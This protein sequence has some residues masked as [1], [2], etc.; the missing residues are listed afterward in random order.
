MR[1]ASIVAFCY[2]PGIHAASNSKAWSLSLGIREDVSGPS[3]STWSQQL[4]EFQDSRT[5][6][7]ASPWFLFFFLF[8]WVPSVDSARWKIPQK[9]LPTPDTEETLLNLSVS[10]RAEFVSYYLRKG[11]SQPWKLLAGSSHHC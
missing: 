3:K 2:N 6:I 8:W 7:R 11:I 1:E 4:P 9:L 10:L 5:P